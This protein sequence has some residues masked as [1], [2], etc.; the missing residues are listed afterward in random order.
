MALELALDG[1][2]RGT[3]RA[4]Q[5]RRLAQLFTGLVLY[6][7]SDALLVRAGLGLDPWT[8][9]HYG[10]ARLTGLTIGTVTI[11]V[12]LVVLLA[13]WPMRQRPGVGTV[14]NVV[15]IGAILDAVLAGLPPVHALGVRLAL[16]VVGVVGTGIATGCYIGAGLGPGPRDGLMTGLA[17]R[18]GR[19]MR[20]VRTCIELT[21]LVS[22]VL[23]GGPVGVGT[24]AYA[25]CIGPLAQHFLRLLD[26]DRRPR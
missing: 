6:G 14:A 10:L 24:V 13:W 3:V 20:L 16:L 9:F 1:A 15:L 8:T 23:L 4:R 11:L 21:V 22:G 19:S 5:P 2:A 7:C 18:T 17:R 26:L 25:L 12:G